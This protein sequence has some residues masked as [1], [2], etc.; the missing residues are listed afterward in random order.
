MGFLYERFLD[1][2]PLS[3][4]CAREGVSRRSRSAPG[5]HFVALKG[6]MSDPETLTWIFEVVVHVQVHE[7]NVGPA[8]KY[9][10]TRSPSSALLPFLFLGR[11]PY[12][13][14]LQ[15]KMVPVV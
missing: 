2:T 7:L 13:N 5:R 15:K 10:D 12:Q 8:G 3:L 11:V 1:H 9:I 6:E 14:R 4:R